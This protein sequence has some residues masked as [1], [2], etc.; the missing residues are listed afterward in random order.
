MKYLSA[1]FVNI[2]PLRMLMSIVLSAVLVFASSFPALAGKS[3]TTKGVEQLP[4]IEEK[5]KEA[6]AKP[7]MS[8]ESIEARSQGALNEV[9]PEAADRDKMYRSSDTMPPAVKQVEKAIAKLKNN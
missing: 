6:L 4:Q 2:R 9:Q 1:L 8:P 7:A 5:S 3:P